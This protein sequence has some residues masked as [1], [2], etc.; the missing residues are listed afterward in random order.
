MLRRSFAQTT[1]WSYE[2]ASNAHVT[3]TLKSLFKVGVLSALEV[4]Y[5]TRT[6]HFFAQKY[7]TTSYKN[8]K[9]QESLSLRVGVMAALS[10]FSEII[11][12]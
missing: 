5:A 1:V 3:S 7:N 11:I 6:K 9:L 12:F 8:L 2:F 4:N 10:N